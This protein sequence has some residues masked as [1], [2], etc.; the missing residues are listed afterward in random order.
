MCRGRAG[1]DSVHLREGIARLVVV[2]SVH[3]AKAEDIV[4]VYIRRTDPGLHLSQI[5]N[6]FSRFSQLVQ[7]EAAKLD[8]LA[9]LWILFHRFCECILRRKKVALTVI[10]EAKFMLNSLR[11]RLHALK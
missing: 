7:T 8:G 5:G 6:R 4:G 9:V 2:L 10:G 11:L 1:R 3:V